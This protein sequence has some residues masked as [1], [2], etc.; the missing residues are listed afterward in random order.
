MDAICA[1]RASEH[2]KGELR[3]G[4]GVALAELVSSYVG[5][6]GVGI[7]DDGGALVIHPFPSLVEAGPLL[8]VRTG[9][10]LVEAVRNGSVAC[11][12]LSKD[13]VGAAGKLRAHEVH[14]VRS[15]LT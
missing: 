2:P 13:L 12:L 6:A 4:T 1:R 10:I 11:N 5:G 9:R 3:G 7:V 15:V 14:G 8:Y